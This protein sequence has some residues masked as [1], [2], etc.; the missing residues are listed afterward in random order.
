MSASSF[1]PE[2]ATTTATTFIVTRHAG[3]KEWLARRDLNGEFY[4][5]FDTTRVKAGDVVVGTAPIPAREPA[6]D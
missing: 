5:H 3:A 6:P 1:A 2:A 4:S